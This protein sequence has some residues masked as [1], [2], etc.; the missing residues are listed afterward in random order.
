MAP[1]P[2]CSQSALETSS[3]SDNWGLAGNAE[4]QAPPDGHNQTLHFTRMYIWVWAARPSIIERKER[5]LRVR[6]RKTSEVTKSTS[7]KW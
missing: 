5:A 1:A 6:S 4:S 7:L 2:C 3:I